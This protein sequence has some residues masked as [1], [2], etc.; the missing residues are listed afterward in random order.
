MIFGMP[1]RF[2]TELAEMANSVEGDRGLAET[3]VLRVYRARAGQI[4]HG[5]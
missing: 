1:W 4:Q 5:P 3:L 2:A